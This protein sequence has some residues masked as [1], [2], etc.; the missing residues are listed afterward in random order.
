M[1]ESPV[2]RDIPSDSAGRTATWHCAEGAVQGGWTGRWAF[3]AERELDGRAQQG[4]VVAKLVERTRG[5]VLLPEIH[6]I[7]PH[8]RICTVLRFI[9]GPICV[10]YYSY[11]NT[12]QDNEVI[13]YFRL[14][15]SSHNLRDLCAKRTT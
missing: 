10:L 11:V 1:S 7:V 15:S 6:D 4:V 9:P 8:P 14:F 3:D 12:A 5:G 13:T 2:D